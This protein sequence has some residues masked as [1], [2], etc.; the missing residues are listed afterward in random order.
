MSLVNSSKPIR[1]VVIG[2]HRDFY[3]Y[4]LLSTYVDMCLSNIKDQYEI[5]IVSGTCRGT[6]Q[7]GERYAKEHGFKCERYPAQWDIYGKKAGPIRNEYMVSIS[8]YVIAFWTGGGR[9]TKSLISL[10]KAYNR[11][12][13]IKMIEG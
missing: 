11:P 5:I 9:G 7:L 6:D 13:R 2:G 3:N 8:D 10:A 4:E 12:L 1:R